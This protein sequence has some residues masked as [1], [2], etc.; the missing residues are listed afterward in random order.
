MTRKEERIQAF[1]LIFEKIFNPENSIDEL[2]KNSC[3]AEEPEVSTFAKMIASTVY[4]KQ[5]EIDSLISEFSV[6]WRIDRIPKVSLSIM[7]LAICEMLYV[8]S[9][10]VSVSINEAVELAKTF[11]TND[12]ASYINGI[13]GSVAKKISS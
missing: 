6:N 13:L 1:T 5:E 2:I 10:P 8:D 7:R 11:A 4:E 12:D 9:I 3:E